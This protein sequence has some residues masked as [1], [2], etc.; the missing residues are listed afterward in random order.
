MSGDRRKEIVHH[1]SEDDLDSL[2]AETDDEKISKQLIFVK[3]LYGGDTFEQ[4]ANR[5]G[6]SESTGSRWAQ[7]ERRRS[8]TPHAELG[9]RAR[10]CLHA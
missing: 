1:L 6:K 5:V 10:G 4:A 3:N 2:L 9:G 7:L 8:R